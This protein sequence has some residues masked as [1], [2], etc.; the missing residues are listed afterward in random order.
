M[1]NVGQASLLSFFKRTATKRPFQ[2]EV[3]ELT[4]SL[5]NSSTVS[6]I[7]EDD[8]ASKEKNSG[9]FMIYFVAF[10][11]AFKLYLPCVLFS[12]E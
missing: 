3:H 8:V 12:L 9:R 1:S 7:L 4:S 11:L 5:A 10:P 6:A 2:P